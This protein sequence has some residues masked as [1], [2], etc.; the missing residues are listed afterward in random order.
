MKGQ[1]N[2]R[3]A[4]LLSVLAL[5]SF[6][7]AQNKGEYSSDANTL[8]LLHMNETSGSTVSDASSFS[9]NGTATGTTIADGKFG[10]SRNFGGG[11]DVV[12]TLNPVLTTATPTFSIEGWVKLS[13]FPIAPVDLYAN[14]GSLETFL[15]IKPGGK[16][17]FGIRG[18]D[19]LSRYD[20]SSTSIGLN[21]WNHVAA[22]FDNATYT[23]NGYINGIKVL[24]KP[25]TAFTVSST[26]AGTS[27]VG[28]NNSSFFPFVGQIDEIR[29][30]T[31]VRTPQ[32][33]N[34]QLPPTNLTALPNVSPLD[35]SVST[36]LSWLNGGGAVGLLRYKIYRGADSTNVSLIDST[37]SIPYLNI[38]LSNGTTY[39]YRVSAVDSTGFEGA[40]SYA[41]S[42][43]TYAPGYFL[44][45]SWKS[46]NPQ[47]LGGFRFTADA[48]LH[49]AFAG[50]V[51]TGYQ[52]VSYLGQFTSSFDTAASI[53]VEVRF[54]TSVTQN[55][56]R[57]RRT[58]TGSQYQIQSPNPFVSVPFTVWDVSNPT[59]PR[60][61]TVAWRDQNNNSVWDPT[62]GND[63][64]E[65][66]FIYHKTYDPTGT[67][68][69]S[70]PPSV[71]DN[72][73]TVGANADVM[74]GLSLQVLSGRSLNE[75][76]GTLS[77]L[78]TAFV[79]A[80]QN[81]TATAGNAQVLLK[82]NKVANTDLKRYRIYSSTSPNPTTVTDSTTA[83]N[84]N[85]TTRMITGLTNG[86]VY[87]FRVAAVDSAWNVSGYSNE[88]NA[89]PFL[90]DTT[91]VKSVLFDGAGRMSLTSPLNVTNQLTIEGWVY[92]IRVEGDTAAIFTRFRG[93]TTTNWIYWLRLIRSSSS[94]QYVAEFAIADSVT[95]VVSRLTT[96]NATVPLFTWTHIAAV[97][98]G[99]TMKIY[100][101]GI[102]A[103][104]SNAA[105]AIPTGSALRLAYNDRN[106]FYGLLDEI[107]FWSI[108]RT[109]T[110]IQNGTRGIGLPSTIPSLLGYWKFEEPQ[111]N[112]TT[113]LD[114]SG[115]NPNATNTGGSVYPFMPFETPGTPSVSLNPSSLTINT[116][117]EIGTGSTGQSLTITNNGSATL[118]GYAN[119]NGADFRA[120]ISPFVIPPAG[121]VNYFASITPLVSGTINGSFNLVS[122]ASTSPTAIGLSAQS[123]LPLQKFDVNNISAPLMRIGKIGFDP[124]GSP[125]G[126]EWPKGSGK[127]MIYSSGLWVIGGVGGALRTAVAFYNSEY[128]AGD[129][130]GGIPSSPTNTKYRVYKI[131][132]GDNAGSNIDYAQWPWDLGAPINLDGSPKFFGDQQL[133]AVY[134][135]FAT[136]PHQVS[137]NSTFKTNPLGAEVQQTT[138]GYNASGNLGN[139]MFLHYKI[140]NRSSSQWDSAYVAFWADTDLGFYGDD[141]TGTDVN[142][143][144]GYVYNG[145]PTDATYGSTPPA[146]GYVMLSGPAGGKSLRAV[147]AVGSLGL[148][149]PTNAT[150]AY[151]FIQGLKRDG[152]P[153]IDPTTG[154]ATKYPF[155]GSPELSTGWLDSNPGDRRL[156]ICSGPL[157]VAAGQ[158]A[159]MDVA[160]V[161][162]Q[163]TDYINSVAKLRSAVAEVKSLGTPTSP[164]SVPQLVSVLPGNGSIIVTMRRNPEA[165][166]LRYRIYVGTTSSPTTPVDSTSAATDTVRTISGINNGTT[167][168]VR[169]KAID[170]AGNESGYSNELSGRPLLPPI[171]GEYGM[172]SSTVLL[173]HMNELSGTIAIDVSN[174]ANNGTADA[175]ATITTA[176]R[177]GNARSYSGT[178]TAK[179]SVPA[180]SNLTFGAADFSAELWVKTTSTASTQ[181]LLFRNTGVAGKQWSLD[182]GSTAPVGVLSFNGLGNNSIGA[183]TLNDG[184]W[185]H[186]AATRQSN[187]VKIYADGRFEGSCVVS[188]PDT[189]GGNFYVGGFN[190]NPTAT[191]DEVRVSNRARAPSEFDLQLPPTTLT[192]TPNGNSIN[193][194]WQNGGGAVPLMR[195]RIYRGA[196]STNVSLID[197]INASTYPNSGMVDGKYFYR[198][199]AVDSTGFESAKSYVASATAN[200]PPTAP[201]NLTA[202]AQNTKIV[203]RW[204][205][206]IDTDFLRYRIYRGTALNPTAKVDSTT[207]G[208]NDTSKTVTG[209]VNGTLYYFRVAAVD[210][211]GNVTYSGNASETPGI[212]SLHVATSG[213]DANLGSA[214]LPLRNIQTALSKA[215]PGDTIKV[216][217]GTYNENLV[218]ATQ[219]IIK[220]GYSSSFTE[221]GRDLIVQKTTL[222]SGGGDIFRD[223]QSSTLDGF[224]VDGTNVPSNYNGITVTGGYTSIT[225]N[226]LTKLHNSGCKV[227]RINAGAGALIK[228]NTLAEN[229]L[230]GGGVSVVG[231]SVASGSSG[232]TIIQNNIITTTGYGIDNNVGTSIADYN[233]INIGLGYSYYGTFTTPGAH[234]I[235]SSPK[236]VYPSGNDYRL[237]GGSPCI[238]AG[239]PADN[240]ASEP[241]PNGGRI[242]IGAYGGT[243]NTTK[244]GFNPSTHVSTNG[245]DA[246][247]G[248]AASPYLTIQYALLHALGDTVKVASGTYGETVITGSPGILRGGY[249]EAFDEATREV[250]QYR[251]MLQA[252]NTTLLVDNYGVSIDGFF[253]DGATSVATIALDLRAPMTLSH[254]VV[255]N[256]KTTLGHGIE[257]AAPVNITNNSFYNCYY[258]LWLNNGAVGSVIKNNIFSTNNYTYYNL[259][260]DGMTSYNDL[261]NSPRAGVY[262]TPGVGEI[263]LNPLFRNTAALDFRLQ[264]SSPAIDKGDPATQYN[265]PDG[266]RN[267]MGAFY[268]NVPPAAPQSLSATAG[269]GQVTLAWRKNQE[270]DFLRYRIYK[271]TSVGQTFLSDSTTGGVSDT[272]KTLTG[273]TNGQIY[274]FRVTAVDS[275]GNVSGYSNEVSARPFGVPTI[276][277]FAP[278]SGPIGTPVTITGTNFN[279][280]ATN[281]IV[282][283]GAVKA[284]VNSAG[285]T[286]LNVAVPVG[287]T[288][289]PITV[290]D[291]TTGLTAYSSKPFIV[292]FPSSRVID[293][294]SF[295]PKVD[296]TTGADPSG[297]VIGDLDGDG[298]PDLVVT[299]GSSNSVSVFRNISASGSLTAS[300]FTSKVDFTTGAGPNSVAIGDVD[301]D[302]KPDLVVT[303]SSSSTVSV[304]RNTSIYGSITA[305]SVAS[306][307]DFTT[308]ANPEGLAIGDAD[309]DGKP[310]LIVANSVSNTV[311][312]FRNTSASGFISTNSFA[313]KVDFTAGAAPVSVAIGD[314]D[315]DGK[316]DFVIV[317]TNS[318]TVSVFRNTSGSGSISTSS[319]AA[320]V[321][322]TTGATPRSIAIGDVDGDGKPD[323][324][325]ANTIGNSVSVFRNTSISGSITASSFASKVD[326]TVGA[327][328]QLVAIGDIDGDGKPDLVSANYNSSTVS[329][330]RNMSTSGSI[331]VSSLASK[332]ELGTGTNPY[333]VAIGDIDGDG[334]PD[335]VVTN[336]GTSTV[337]VLRNTV[338]P[339]IVGEYTP[340]AN[341]VLLLHM[342]ET[343]GSTVSDASNYAN[344]GTATGTTIVDGRF[345]KARSFNGTN[346]R[347]SISNE[348]Q[349]DFISGDFTVEAWVRPTST[350][351][352]QDIVSKYNSF[353]DNNTSYRLL[354]LSGKLSFEFYNA[355]SGSDNYFVTS[356]E[357]VALQGEWHHY[358]A[359]I[360]SASQKVSLFRDGVELHS[361]I[362]ATITFPTTR[363][364]SS[365]PL[366]IGVSIN[367]Q[368]QYTEFLSGSIDEVRVSNIAHSPQEFNLQLPPKNLSAVSA[369]TVAIDLSWQNGGGALPL[370]KYRI[371]RGA[372]STS[373]TLVDS[374]TIGSKTISGLTASTKYF[375]R[376]SAVDSTGFE[377]AKSYAASATTDNQTTAPLTPTLATPADGSTSQL[378]TLTLSWNAASGAT[379]Y[380]LQLSTSNT[381]ATT[382]IDDATITGT[383]RQVGPLA[384]G[385]QHYWHVQAINSVGPSSYSL[386]RT[387][388]TL[389][390]PSPPVSVS[391]SP[392]SASQVNL[393][394]TNAAGVQDS[395]YIERKQG[396]G[397]SYA[398]IA[399]LVGTSTSYQ[400]TGLAEAVQYYFRLQTRNGAGTSAYSNET[401]ATTL[402]VT[403]PA[404]PIGPQISPTA[405]TNNS[406]FTL[407][408]TNPSDASGIS[409]LWY[410]INAAPT[411]GTP[412]TSINLSGPSAQV[413]VSTV[414]SNQVYFYLE[415]AAG[416]KNT[417]SA[418]VLTARFENVSP[419]VVHDS[420]SVSAFVTGS[421]ASIGIAATASDGHSGMQSLQ[422]QYKRS[423]RP[424]LEASSASYSSASGGTALI[425]STFLSTNYLFGVDYRVVATDN[426]GNLATNPVHSIVITV[427]APISRTDAGGNAVVQPSASALPSGAA[428]EYAY[429]LFSVPLNLNPS[430][431][432]PYDVFVTQTGLPADDAKTWRLFRY[433]SSRAASDPYDE[434][435][436]FQNSAVVTPGA[437]FFLILKSGYT[438]KVGPGTMLKAEDYAKS[439][440]SLVNGYNFVGN[441]FNFD[442]LTDSLSLANGVSLLGRTW[443]FV[444]V[445][446]NQFGWR[447]LE[448]IN[449]PRDTMKSWEG[450]VIRLDNGP[451]QLRFNIADRPH[452]L[453]PPADSLLRVSARRDVSGSWLG[454]ISVTRT[455]NGMSDNSNLLGVLP[456]A[457]NDFDLYDAYKPPP[458]GG[459]GISVGFASENGILAQDIRSASNDGNVWNIVL[460]TPGTNVDVRLNLDEMPSGLLIDLDSKLSVSV[461]GSYSATINTRAGTRQFRFVKGSDAF[462]AEQAKAFSQIPN[463]PI[464]FQ[465]YPNP[466]NPRT[467]IE[468]VLP[469]DGLAV[470]RVFNILGEE[471]A[472]ILRQRVMAGL[473][474]ALTFDGTSLPSGIY[475]VQLEFEGWRKITKIL[476]MK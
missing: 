88:V 73:L 329:I 17:L 121:F 183:T 373:M 99:A 384:T 420:N 144:F 264:N 178:L 98:D 136:Q 378:P 213:N 110:Q 408:W 174:Y 282:Y 240:F 435:S 51:T 209:L 195:Y 460:Q 456:E 138:Y 462:I 331:S 332:V 71:I 293:T 291:T 314:V 348:T 147:A 204:N 197:S 164:P 97:Y 101:N 184:K 464:L 316:P 277:S 186:V 262:T 399:S 290:T 153:Y 313:A 67:T 327:S 235:N 285:S 95:N 398:R 375:F 158:S 217:G 335:V 60:Q 134:N 342:N 20:S 307:V 176:G 225:H 312:V 427:S 59:S 169:L 284:T 402:D 470:V 323:L 253:F 309:G 468:V 1:R 212:I 54:S 250:H 7:N 57:L 426:A 419:T 390:L 355:P 119:Y 303:N 127:S 84:L 340:D 167:Y 301:G 156:M 32:E 113:F 4:R 252:V 429:R 49:K 467:T 242:D 325:V 193:L 311:S 394:W 130:P 148:L 403:A 37:T 228:N 16:I 273:L 463:E 387:F 407:S 386:T 224:V 221:A 237:K 330:L 376:V 319:F 297:V 401:P 304:F 306:K 205:K 80:P 258:A 151:N 392:V 196:D 362:F 96:G 261:Y 233:C 105:V 256:V 255:L 137:G 393:S 302:S 232:S 409:K 81:L 66:V 421:P 6:T 104:Q 14:A 187:T 260:A 9:N 155:S 79:F 94:Q 267:D 430:N 411:S 321:E 226:V 41:A 317:N 168:Y 246:N 149:D 150:Q 292:T 346:D 38:G 324:V 351:G 459:H 175:G 257:A 380:R 160:I 117:L 440:L 203:L 171:F 208:I 135:D 23:M 179:M 368:N 354:F 159:E 295:A 61:L 385:T 102:L 305:S 8:L 191:L 451:T 274:Y 78:P 349:F 50:G 230:S 21:L 471:V 318:N 278:T 359:V 92:P 22:T 180:S 370:M 177:F 391:A 15:A 19:G 68:Q 379:S 259:A 128:L 25:F 122:N 410:R 93:S 201:Q 227:I 166:I 425:Q 265:D 413:P 53:P 446:G 31:V 473:T 108:A 283:F 432:T 111:V 91:G 400:N 100:L 374:A 211:G 33:F 139:V 109:A 461:E 220:G 82:W 269:N 243:Q 315:G 249:S 455:D 76:A 404:S 244:S 140:I 64:V 47:W 198:L 216:S 165:D 89:T 382:V 248:S 308:G 247:D 85:D 441:P 418:A 245:S 152:T 396:V 52:L 120:V 344:N 422:L 231:I 173:L 279:A 200:Q 241:S 206:S 210:S 10:K 202:T 26:S 287:A 405:W 131:N 296:F 44:T 412:G 36:T 18:S 320:K 437:A 190:F 416:N 45:T 339:P 43:T 428:V 363:N 381:F 40:K 129:A 310:D 161:V 115:H 395:V 438:I 185:H 469:R 188:L 112:P 70:M 13:A 458:L 434:F 288:F 364:N 454:K 367:N 356:D 132:R 34:L 271:G 270:S 133:F 299:N 406:T 336:W 126:F 476:L 452:S 251:T 424:W 280:T 450:L 358:G 388:T 447:A 72:E 414:G 443:R 157:N 377:G 417:G 357:S 442:I 347:M 30:S 352:I 5:C 103:S 371:Y 219:V 365:D 345:G 334:K 42:A 162:A 328:P 433:N 436:S 268:N 449:N 58:G 116:V 234:D 170:F 77:I 24:S 75:S 223:N 27:Y 236:L 254:C 124:F 445:G 457:A 125:G 218:T 439:G 448:T 431:Q 39:Y 475:F 194:T 29:V 65:I 350:S 360:N 333:S 366:R 353:T 207:G 239:N 465:N 214:T 172:D 123:F 56:Y 181:R 397:G 142:G 272:S 182:L 289:A 90:E 444:G 74:Y 474:T 163:G 86:Q 276:A 338:A 266:T 11:T 199:T 322:F 3:F 300:S 341:A 229:A 141:F 423:G 415:D 389:A 87:Y 298:K 62:V 46:P 275:A 466:F 154:G 337:S 343:S 83:G 192:A 106:F 326:F 189:T 361:T 369:S 372:D 215:G 35:G 286:S 12:T 145:S 222:G 383:S 281:N 48:D 2:F 263:G 118:V 472:T 114:A 28:N 143:E 69:F 55:A 238:D 107:R 63:G 146:V 294:T 453:A